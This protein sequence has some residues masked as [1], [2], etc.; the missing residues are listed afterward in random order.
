MIQSKRFAETPTAAGQYQLI[1][2]EEVLRCIE[3]QFSLVFIIAV[4]GLGRAGKST[5]M[6]A[7]IGNLAERNFFL[8]ISSED[9]ASLVCNPFVATPSNKPV[10]HGVDVSVIPLRPGGAWDISDGA[11]LL[12]VDIEGLRNRDTKGL[13]LLLALST[14]LG[15]HLLFVDQLLND[16]CQESLNRLV[17]SKMIHVQPS[18]DETMPHLHL[19]INRNYLA[20][21]D[22][23]ADHWFDANG[24]ESA[25]V[26]IDT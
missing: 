13:D 9:C 16:A 3:S 4:V 12:F 2:D 7:I 22:D 8:E 26:I 6:N 19:V 14:Q 11:C 1:L 17:L 24:N 25:K 18:E 10:T 15:R 23:C 5:T 21:D 20:V